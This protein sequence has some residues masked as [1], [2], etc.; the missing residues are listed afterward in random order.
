M[1]WHLAATAALL[2]FSPASG[3]PTDPWDVLAG[4]ALHNQAR[5][6]SSH[7]GDGSCNPK[8]A[9]IRREWYVICIH[10]YMIH[11]ISNPQYERDMS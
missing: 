3:S 10:L 9:S 7:E 6:H 5:Y 1:R 11:R 4:Q 2:A 8:T